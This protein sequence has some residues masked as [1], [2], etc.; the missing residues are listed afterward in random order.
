MWSIALAVYIG[1]KWLT[2]QHAAVHNAPLWK[3]VAYLTAW[4]GM[5]A[6]A[7]LGDTS[8]VNHSACRTIDWLAAIAKVA[9]GVTLLFGVSRL[10]P[11]RSAYLI[12][13]I[14][15][16]GLVLI[17]HF[18]AF[19]LLSCWWRRV[20]IDAP[21]LMNNPLASTSLAE[22][23]G[24]RWNTAFRDLT[25]RFLFRPFASWFGARGGVLR[26]LPV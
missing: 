26:R 4:P 25:Y 21:A 17:L 9:C 22:F 7:F 23:W 8:S 14:G 6:T 3:H 12:G 19:Q 24:R 16:V 1:C 20:G 18:G 15:M 10:I 13:W 11:P 2:W 5:D